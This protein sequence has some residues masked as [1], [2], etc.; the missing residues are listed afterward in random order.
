MQNSSNADTRRANSV[1]VVEHKPGTLV[2]EDATILLGLCR[3]GRLYE[4]EQW[5]ASGRSVRTSEN[6]K[7]SPLDVAVD[8]GFHSLVELLA[9]N[10][11]EPSVKNRALSRA[12]AN[13][14]LDLVQLLT[15]LGADIK[16]VSLLHVFMTWD[17][18]MIRFFLD[19][20]ADAVTGAPFAL[21]FA[22][23]IRTSLRPFVEYKK[24]HPEL[25]IELQH[26]ACAPL[27]RTGGRS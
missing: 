3:A 18:T 16:A 12:I 7:R 15:A 17:P 9:R 19:N 8:Q 22:E 13:K 20:G 11:Y 27:F 14:R 5:I 23:R 24:G 4:V 6:L 21:A 10:E 25:A 1:G 26:Q 2:Q